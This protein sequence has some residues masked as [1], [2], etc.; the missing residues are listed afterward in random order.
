MT[1]YWSRMAKRATPY[2]PGLQLNEP[3][4]IKLNTNENPYP[5][6]PNV[7]DAIEKEGSNH[8][9]LYPSSTTVDLRQT[10]GEVYAL[11][12]DEV[13]IGE[14]SDEVLGVLFMAYFVTAKKIS[15]PD[16][17]YSSYH[18]CASGFNF[19]VILG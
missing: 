1:K 5:P 19:P 4:I 17:T 8:L 11:T 18:V 6:S 14:G 15:Y 9:Q 3:N 10:I 16:I 13:F 2:V 7:M 12:A